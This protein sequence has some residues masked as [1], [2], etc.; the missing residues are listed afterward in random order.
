MHVEASRDPERMA[1]TW[2]MPKGLAKREALELFE[3]TIKPRTYA[4]EQF[5]YDPARGL[6]VTV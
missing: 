2:P 6:A 3:R 4:F 1:H 5:R